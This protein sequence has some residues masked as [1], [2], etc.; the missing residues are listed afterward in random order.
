[1]SPHPKTETYKNPL[2]I[3]LSN[4]NG[5]YSFDQSTGNYFYDK[6]GSIDSLLTKYDK[7]KIL[8]TLVAHM[9]DT[10]M[11]NSEYNG[12]KLFLGILSFQALQILVTYEPTDK[13]GDIA[14]HWKGFVFP[15]SDLNGLIIAREEWKKVIQTKT[16]ILQ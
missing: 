16:Y 4:L 9:A 1:M 3:A 6:N 7:V 15:V 5:K 13:S 2:M 10:T 11:T 12:K 8:D 14:G